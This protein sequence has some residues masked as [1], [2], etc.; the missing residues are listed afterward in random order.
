MFGQQD[1]SYYYL[2]ENP[3]P[4][5]AS[6]NKESSDK[7]INGGIF[8]GEICKGEVEQLVKLLRRRMNLIY[9]QNISEF[10]RGVGKSAL[11]AHAWRVLNDIE[12]KVTTTFLRCQKKDTAQ[13]LCTNVIRDW[14]RQG[15]LWETCINCLLQYVESATKPEIAFPGAQRLSENNWPVD[16]V[17]LRSYLVYSPDRLVRSLSGWACSK[18]SSLQK[19]IVE[20]FFSTYLSEPDK[21]LTGYSRVIKKVNS[22]EIDLLHNLL[23]FMELA[24][25]KYHYMFFDQFE[26]AVTGL[27]GKSLI[28]FSSGMRRLLDGSMNRMSII[29]TLHPGAALTLDGPDAQEFITLAPLD[30]RH[31]VDIELLEPKEAISL[32][33][34]YMDDFRVDGAPNLLYPFTEEA[35]QEISDGVGGQIRGFLTGMNLAIEEGIEADFSEID[36]SFVKSNYESIVGRIHEDRI[37]FK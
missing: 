12:E 15:V 33:K 25:Y 4:A 28:D 7:R 18:K 14:H 20:F 6:F 9:C 22:D 23:L 2:K 19:E 16:L 13:T 21:F 34:T 30:S 11:I 8:N 5:D 1:Y 31:R 32:A 10:V 37:G 26:D 36:R 27:S 17:D 24:G 3:F 29:V 35:I